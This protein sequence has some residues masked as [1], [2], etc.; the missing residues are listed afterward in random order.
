M[1]VMRYINFAMAATVGL[2]C[3]KSTRETC[4]GD[5]ST[6][7]A[8][9]AAE[10]DMLSTLVTAVKAAGAMDLIT[11]YRDYTLLAPTNEAFATLAETVDLAAVLENKDLLTQILSLHLIRMEYSS[12]ELSDGEEFTSLEGSTLTVKIDDKVSF[13]GPTNSATVISAD[14]AA[15]NGVVHVIDTVLLPEM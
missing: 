9:L 3:G 2:A 10:S 1:K 15:C 6:T 8:D 7:L 13:E 14:L 11:G 4:H 12:D 5:F